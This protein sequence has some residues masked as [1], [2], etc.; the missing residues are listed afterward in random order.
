ML[1]ETFPTMNISMVSE[2]KLLMDEMSNLKQELIS[3]KKYINDMKK[4][5]QQKDK[6]IE[7]IHNL[8]NELNKDI[9]CTNNLGQTFKE[10]GLNNLLTTILIRLH[11]VEAS[12][13]LIN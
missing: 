10:I 13:K 3:N 11:N 9:T 4:E 1:N 2:L 8:F 6:K 7:I 12:N 5:L